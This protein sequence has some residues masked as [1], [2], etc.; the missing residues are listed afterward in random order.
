MKVNHNYQDIK[1]LNN[2]YI[3]QD[4]ILNQMNYKIIFEIQYFRVNLKKY[5]IIVKAVKCKFM[6]QTF[7]LL[8][9][10]IIINNVLKN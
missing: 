9:T 3:Y 10:I 8:V 6:E 7:K 2:N 1:N 4:Q 5:N